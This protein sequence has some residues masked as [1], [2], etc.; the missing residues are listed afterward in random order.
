MGTLTVR[1]NLAFSANLRL[2][3]TITDEEKRKRV[4]DVI[5]ELGLQDCANT[6][7]CGQQNGTFIPLESMKDLGIFRN[8]EDCTKKGV[9]VS[10]K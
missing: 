3:N 5:Q 2:P 4:E 9:P 6:R 8:T 7:V 1:E 10:Q